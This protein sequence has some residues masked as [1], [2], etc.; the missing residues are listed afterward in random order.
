M[1]CA[2][3]TVVVLVFPYLQLLFCY[4]ALY[5]PNAVVLDAILSLYVSSQQSTSVRNM[6]KTNLAF[7]SL[8]FAPST[9]LA[10]CIK[11]SLQKVPFFTLKGR[12]Q[13][14]LQK[15]SQSWVSLLH[16]VTTPFPMKVSP[17]GFSCSGNCFQ[18][19]TP[20]SF[21]SALR[22]GRERNVS[23]TVHCMEDFHRPVCRD[24]RWAL[25]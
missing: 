2:M 23:F 6:N 22:S 25:S 24:I 12:P 9:M 5:L 21:I 13:R 18:Q 20:L 17:P 8:P 19:V 4:A 7:W 3:F 16:Q 11:C 14:K 1:K 15:D 10:I